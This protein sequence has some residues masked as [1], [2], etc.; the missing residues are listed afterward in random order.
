M[1]NQ[2]ER[3]LRDSLAQRGAPMRIPLLLLIIVL[4]SQTA[5]AFAGQPPAQGTPTAAER[6]CATAG[7]SAGIP[8]NR[9]PAVARAPGKPL[10]YGTNLAMYDTS[11]DV[12]NGT[13][14]QALLRSNGV[15]IVRM[16]F[17]YTLTDAYE[18]QGL[19]AIR[20]MYAAPLVIVHG[21][22]DVNVMANDLHILKLVIDVFGANTVY[23]EFG[24]E[25]EL[26]GVSAEAYA[27]S[28]NTVV[29]CMKYLAP[30]YNYIGP[31]NSFY[32]PDYVA[33][34]DR[35]ANPRPD[36]NSWHEYACANFDSNDTCMRYL[37]NW[38]A[39][40]IGMNQA[41]KAATGSAIPIMLTEWNL[42]DRPDP[43]YQDATFMHAWMT[44]ALATL[45]ANRANGLYAAMQY[46]ATNNPNFGLIDASNNLTPAGQAFFHALSQAL[47]G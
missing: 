7:A 1:G 46:C 17:R 21:P 36:F 20:A 23:V 19:L 11:D 6:Q 42:D 27:A 9:A 28:W 8:V 43:R 34:F 24:N 26:A 18:T 39:H 38:T 5:C 37:N 47:T 3:Q 33:T 4:V 16:P 40:I 25:S 45:D 32:N 12:V 13:G 35:L 10:I 29:A 30:T 44:A 15:P 41:V 2:R 31:A 14:A 22:T